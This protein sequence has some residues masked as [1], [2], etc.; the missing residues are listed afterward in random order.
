[1]FEHKLETAVESLVG[2]HCLQQAF[3]GGAA[4]L[5]QRCRLLRRNRVQEQEAD[6]SHKVDGFIVGQALAQQ[7]LERALALGCDGVDAP[8]WAVALSFFSMGDPAVGA[9]PV[10][11]AVGGGFFQVHARSQVAADQFVQLVAVHLLRAQQSE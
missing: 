2:A 7:L 10:E 8:G 1:M 4:I 5:Q 3:D 6:V 9:H 11:Q